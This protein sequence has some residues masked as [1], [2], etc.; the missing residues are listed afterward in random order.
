MSDAERVEKLE[1]ALID[2]YSILDLY[3]W[4]RPKIYGK[5]SLYG[6]ILESWADA[7]ICDH[8]PGEYEKM[9]PEWL[10]SLRSRPLVKSM[11]DKQ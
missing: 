10:K 4:H 2:M 8:V 7:L 3:M 6:D 11:W 1:Q 9:S 5:G